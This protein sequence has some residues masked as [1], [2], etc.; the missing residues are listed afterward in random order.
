MLH[1]DYPEWQTLTL[2]GGQQITHKGKQRQEVSD[3]VGIHAEVSLF[4]NLSTWLT[5]LR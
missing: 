2:E 4:G 1:P 3:E 5:Y